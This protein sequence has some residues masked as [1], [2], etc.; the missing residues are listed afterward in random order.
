MIARETERFQRKINAMGVVQCELG[1]GA[2]PVKRFCA[3]GMRRWTAAFF[4]EQVICFPVWQPSP[5][6][7]PGAC[8]GPWS[9]RWPPT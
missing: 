5:E 9:A 2:D 4:F 8:F 3:C 7:D 6:I 1:N